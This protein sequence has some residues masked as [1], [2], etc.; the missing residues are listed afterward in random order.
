MVRARTQSTFGRH[1]FVNVLAKLMAAK[2]AM[3]CAL[4]KCRAL[5]TSTMRGQHWL[6]PAHD[7][8]GD[9][10]R[11]VTFNSGATAAFPEVSNEANLLLRRGG[12]SAAILARERHLVSAWIADALKVP[13]SSDARCVFLLKSGV[14]AEEKIIR[15]GGWGLVSRPSFSADEI[16]SFCLLARMLPSKTTI[17]LD[18]C[19]ARY[20]GEYAGRFHSVRTA[21]PYE[22]LH[23]AYHAE[24]LA[25]FL[26]DEHWWSSFLTCAQETHIFYDPR[27]GRG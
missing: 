5:S 20:A 10:P 9:W 13:P 6:A 14:K 4:P 16:E 21:G 7:M 17:L 2:S 18:A 3:R 25:G 8:D 12:R 1:L 23:M 26:T 27:R 22:Q 24:F 15:G 11:L 19:C